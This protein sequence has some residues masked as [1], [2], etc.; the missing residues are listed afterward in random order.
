[1]AVIVMC[2]YQ[3]LNI[4]SFR[5]I[6]VASHSIENRKPTALYFFFFD[7][8]FNCFHCLDET[9]R[10]M[11]HYI[12]YT[13]T[14]C[15]SSSCPPSNLFVVSN[16]EA[17]A[18]AFIKER[19]RTK[20]TAGPNLENSRTHLHILSHLIMFWRIPN[21]MLFYITYNNN[22]NLIISLWCH[23]PLYL[24]NSAISNFGTSYRAL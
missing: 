23:F 2:T 5:V 12:S 1:M 18:W 9:N 14:I 22:S 24:Y 17:C 8:T 7:L 13:A 6:Q 15:L 11:T 10:M 20:L 21:P 3:Q 19:T 4:F 16:W